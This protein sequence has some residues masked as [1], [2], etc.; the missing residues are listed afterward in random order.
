MVRR[1]V[2]YPTS[3]YDAL[4]NLLHVSDP[5][6]TDWAYFEGTLTRRADPALCDTTAP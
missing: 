1:V 5:G 4:E 2:R 3:H 6:A